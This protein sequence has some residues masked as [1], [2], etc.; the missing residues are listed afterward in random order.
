MYG[1]IVRP[2]TQTERI[3]LCNVSMN[4]IM[5]LGKRYVYLSKDASYLK[6][7]PLNGCYYIGKSAPYYG[8]IIYHNYMLTMIR[9]RLIREF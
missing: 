6:N 8:M 2:P 5:S 3:K 9:V 4:K 7:T 1:N